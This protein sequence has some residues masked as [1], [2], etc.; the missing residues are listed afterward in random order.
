MSYYA[1]IQQALFFGS[2]DKVVC[3]I[4]IVDDVL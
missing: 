1:F 3:I 4:L 2:H